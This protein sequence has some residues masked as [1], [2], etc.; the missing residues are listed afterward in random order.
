M[1]MIRKQQQFTLLTSPDN[2]ML[3]LKIIPLEATAWQ[4][5]VMERDPSL[6]S[7]PMTKPKFLVKFAT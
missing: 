3:T 4:V 2:P 7:M 5:G 6:N 1:L